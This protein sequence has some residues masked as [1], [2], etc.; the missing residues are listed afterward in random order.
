[1]RARHLS[2]SLAP[3]LSLC[4]CFPPCFSLCL[5]IT[6]SHAAGHAVFSHNLTT[7]HPTLRLTTFLSC[8]I[9]SGIKRPGLWCC[10][11]SFVS[12]VYGPD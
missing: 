7:V 9:G 4:V 11:A 12:L 5:W 6:P 1:M 8:P 3:S 2:F 10:C